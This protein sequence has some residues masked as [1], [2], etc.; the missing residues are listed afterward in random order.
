MGKTEVTGYDHKQKC[1]LDLRILQL[2]NG[3]P[4][5]VM[6][7][8]PIKYLGVRLTITGDLTF[9]RDCVRKKT[10]DTIKQLI[11]H[12]YHPQR[13]HWVVQVAN[14][15]IFRYSADIANWD[16][17]ETVKLE[18][19]WMH[20]FKKVWKVNASLPDVTFWAEPEQGGLETPKAR[21]ITGITSETI[22]LL[23]QCMCSDDDLRQVTIQDM[24]QAIAHL[25][26]SMIEEAQAELQW[27][28]EDWKQHPSLCQ[29][30]PACIS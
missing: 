15:P 30:F 21:A 24:S 25:G 28:G 1:P 16:S 14:I 12:M 22:S 17:Q 29:R 6:Q 20:A 27:N 11:K 10:L 18:N 5:I 9:E 7:W 8:D 13:I 19:L 26:C 4:K 3:K 23:N 2:I